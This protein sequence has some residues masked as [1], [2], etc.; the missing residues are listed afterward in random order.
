MSTYVFL[1]KRYEIWLTPP[2]PLAGAL[3]FFLIKFC[4]LGGRLPLGKSLLLNFVILNLREAIKKIKKLIFMKKFHK[5]VPPPP[6]PPQWANPE[7]KRK[8]KDDQKRNRVQFY[9]KKMDLA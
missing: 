4:F 9:A 5:T 7:Q 3:Q 1:N 8:V 6:P 2:P